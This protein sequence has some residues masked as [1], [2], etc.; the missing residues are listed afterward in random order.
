M[1]ININIL[2]LKEIIIDLKWKT[3]TI[4]L[5]N[6]IKLKLLIK[7]Y[8]VNRFYWVIFIN[9][10]IVILFLL[11]FTNLKFKKSEIKLFY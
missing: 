5:Y 1:L 9:K 10:Y 6:F 2:I 11:S 3:V 4:H 8:T 7:L